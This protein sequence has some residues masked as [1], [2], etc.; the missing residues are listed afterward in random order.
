MDTYAAQWIGKRKNQE[1]SYGVKHFPEGTLAVVCD[2]MGG[3]DCG[4]IASHLSVEAFIKSFDILP[5]ISIVESLKISLD[6]AN[7]IVKKFFAEN[8]R[9]G[10]STLLAT[11][12]NSR[13]LW[14]VSVG[15][16]PLFIWRSGRLN[17]LNEDHSQRYL[18]DDIVC[19]Q[20]SYAL[21]NSNHGHI[22]RSALTGDKIEMIDAPQ[23]AYP[24]LPRDRIILSSDG[25]LDFLAQY[26]TSPRLMMMM[27]RR[28]GS[29]AGNIVDAC[30]EL[31][32]T[33]A[34]NVTIL[35]I[36]A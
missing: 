23:Y 2:G 7:K 6:Y 22:L 1:D 21:S 34:D 20:R 30:R 11:F 10:G 27:G 5:G 25:S 32:V 24:L 35:T 13:S 26:G 29:L 18:I 8:S 9:F 33:H 31:D 16:S 14:W 15:D 36:D 12:S 28:D 19:G 3:H 17:R 4:E